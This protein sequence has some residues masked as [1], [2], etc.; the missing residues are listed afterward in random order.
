ML[1][2]LD[3]LEPISVAHGLVMLLVSGIH[4]DCII[5]GLAAVSDAIGI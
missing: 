3:R 1:G 4:D 2:L 5:G